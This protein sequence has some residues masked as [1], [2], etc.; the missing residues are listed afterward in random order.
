MLRVG[1]A[2][3]VHTRYTGKWSRGF[4]V[5][6]VVGSEYRLRRVS[7]QRLLPVLTSP[8]DLRS[9]STPDDRDRA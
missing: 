8:A 4:E 7:D 6:E 9:A 2:V 3:E 5:A 1:E